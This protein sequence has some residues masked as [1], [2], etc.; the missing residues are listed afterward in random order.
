MSQTIRIPVP[1]DGEY[2]LLDYFS[3]L[4][5]EEF[6]EV[7]D[8][9]VSEFDDR[10]QTDE[11]RVTSVVEQTDSITVHYEIDIS[12]HYGCSDMDY[13]KTVPRTSRGVRDGPDW[14]FQRYVQPPRRST[15]DEF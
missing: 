3:D 6:G 1:P 5:D 15:H 11:I 8:F 2:D 9:G 7:I 10:A 12:A 13:A 14:V 4:L